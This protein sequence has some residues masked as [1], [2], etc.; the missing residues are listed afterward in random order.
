MTKMPEGFKYWTLY[1]GIPGGDY[2]DT[3]W[4]MTSAISEKQLLTKTHGEDIPAPEWIA[5]GDPKLKR[6]LYLY[7]HEDDAHPDRFYEME[8]KMTV[9]GFGRKGIDKYLDSVPQSVSIGLLESDE[10]G[11]IG[12]A[13]SG[14]QGEHWK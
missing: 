1:E 13:I 7:H 4:W 8:K 10:H 12:R 6:S 14:N 9:F 5:F 11:E 2:N 3:D